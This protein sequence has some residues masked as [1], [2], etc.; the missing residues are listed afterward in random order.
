MKNISVFCG[1]HEG[2][3]SRYAQ[4]AK[5]I[6]EILAAKGINAWKLQNNIKNKQ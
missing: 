5:K 4:D 2:K 1:A 6:G 3:N